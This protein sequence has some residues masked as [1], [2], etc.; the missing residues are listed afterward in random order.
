VRRQIVVRPSPLPPDE[1]GQ[2][3]RVC[4]ASRGPW[5]PL[6]TSKNRAAV[7]DSTPV[8]AGAADPSNS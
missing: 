4:T 6:V 3:L 1:D 8:R 5:C 7:S 2:G